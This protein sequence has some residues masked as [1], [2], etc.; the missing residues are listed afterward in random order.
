[1]RSKIVSKEKN[2]ECLR[3]GFIMTYIQTCHVRCDN[4][5]AELTCSDK[6]SFW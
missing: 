4:C 6:G 2:I 5:G 3:C 1:M